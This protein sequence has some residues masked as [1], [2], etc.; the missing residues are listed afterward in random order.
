MS[1]I[2][3][4]LK[5]GKKFATI[6][7]LF[8]KFNFGKPGVCILCC[9]FSKALL[10]SNNSFQIPFSTPCFLLNCF[11]V[12][13]KLRESAF[14]IE[15]RTVPTP[16]VSVRIFNILIFLIF[17]KLDSFSVTVPA[18]DPTQEKA[19]ARQLKEGDQRGPNSE[20][21]PASNASLSK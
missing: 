2:Q 14:T 17:Q 18:E 6:V 12:T 20:A 21:K 7:I 4:S 11:D 19:E 15:R 10:S 1:K 13:L 5:L 9:F 3:L 8:T 16:F